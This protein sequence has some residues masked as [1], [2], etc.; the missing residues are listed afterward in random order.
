MQ[1]EL[2]TATTSARKKR[3]VG[4]AF[5]PD[6]EPCRLESLTYFLAGVIT[7]RPIGRARHKRSMRERIV[8]GDDT[9]IEFGVNP[10][11]NP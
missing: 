8:G 4:Q 7:T 1:P 2:A 6:S 3:S 9:L 11:S 5:Q 10:L